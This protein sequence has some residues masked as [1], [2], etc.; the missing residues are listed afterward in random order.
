MNKLE[1]AA[2]IVEGRN[3]THFVGVS[4]Y[5]KDYRRLCQLSLKELIKVYQK[6]VG[7]MNTENNK[8]LY[9]CYGSNLH[10][11]QMAHRCPDAKVY[12][13]GVIKNHRLV[14]YGVASIEPHKNEDCPVGVWEITEADEENLDI[15]EGWPHLYRKETVE[16]VMSNG[17]TVKA[18]VYIMNRSGRESMPTDGY[19]DTIL[20][21]YRS[22]KLPI[23]YLTN[24]V[25]RVRKSN[26]HLG[27]IRSSER[28]SLTKLRV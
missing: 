1:M 6:E 8:K 17:E 23:S 9:V 12:G 3:K 21:G 20:S 2:Q 27:Y 4:E 14:F 5:Y 26:P 7:V 10:I 28:A 19:Y 11:G 16:V 25:K 18:M 13:S 24:C 22:F 15:Y